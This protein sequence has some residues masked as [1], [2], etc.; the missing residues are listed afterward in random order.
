MA[1][2]LGAE[3]PIKSGKSNNDIGFVIFISS[4]N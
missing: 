3:Q 2:F 4:Y 1:I